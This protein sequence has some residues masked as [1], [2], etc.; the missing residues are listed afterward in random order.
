MKQ[1]KLKP[2]L[3]EEQI[4][5]LEGTFFTPD[6][7]KYHITEDTKVFNENGDILAV[8]KKNAVPKNILNNSRLSFRKAA[9]ESN[10]RGLASGLIGQKYK[11]GDKIGGRTIG[12]IDG[13]RYTPINLKDGKLSNTS[14][15]LT[16]NSGLMGF[17]DRYPRIPYCRSTMYNQKNF[18]GFKNCL[19]YIKC[20]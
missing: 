6:L 1:I 2:I 11:V 5:K 20:K 13:T 4:K 10:N 18:K 19:P 3:T 7:I 12:K 9:G 16:V 8:Y 14:Y 17:S 15:A